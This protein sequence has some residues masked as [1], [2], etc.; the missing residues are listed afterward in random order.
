MLNRVSRV[1]AGIED[2]LHPGSGV[3]STTGDTATTCRIVSFDVHRRLPMTRDRAIL[4]QPGTLGGRAH[5][6]LRPEL[7]A[8]VCSDATQCVTLSYEDM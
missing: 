7:F 2:P 1:F 4:G 8:H 3:V 5:A 6:A